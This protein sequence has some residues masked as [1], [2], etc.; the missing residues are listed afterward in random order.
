MGSKLDTKIIWFDENIKNEENKSYFN[1]LQ[2]NF[3]YFYGYQSLDEGFKKL[4][5]LEFSTIFIIVSGR[6]FGRYI[7]K[8][9]ENIH[10]IINLPYTY[11]FTS[12]NFKRA[13]LKQIHDKE[14]SISYDTMINANDGFYNPGGVYDD[15]DD[16]LDDIKMTVKKI[17]SNIKIVPRLKEK[18][19]YEGLLTFEYLESEEDLLAPALY[20]DIITNKKIT[21][22]D[23]KRFYNFILSYNDANLNQ[24]VKNYIYLDMYHMKYYANIGQESIQLR[25]IFIKF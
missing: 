11:I 2:D 23:C 9:K 22:E 3:N 13:L 25:V 4:Y 8:I 17:D 7:R 6:L 5:N 15:F 24:L 1:K 14:N 19:N 16:L 21:R 10:K 12:P 20:K 18:I